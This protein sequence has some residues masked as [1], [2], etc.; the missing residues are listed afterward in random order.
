MTQLNTK[1][2]RGVKRFE[3]LNDG[4]TIC[5]ECGGDGV[6]V[7]CEG[8]GKDDGRFCNTCG[9]TGICPLCD[10]QGQLSPAKKQLEWVGI[11]RE[12]GFD[13]PD[14]P[15]LLEAR[16]ERPPANKAEVVAYLR[17]GKTM[18]LSPG[19]SGT[20][21]FDPARRTT[22][23]SILTDGT[24]AWYKELAYYVENYDVPLNERF[25]QHVAARGYKMPDVDTSTLTLSRR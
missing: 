7:V 18:V 10:G 1:P 16:G 15:S 2:T 19:A 6:C 21:V 24:Y 22:T 14:F 9:A 12:L 5:Y 13:R 3:T 25:E 20:D 17:A 4:W 11:Y 23:K 8:T